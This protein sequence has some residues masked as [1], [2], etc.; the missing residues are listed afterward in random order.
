[1]NDAMDGL[2]PDA[3]LPWRDAHWESDLATARDA[4]RAL[5]AKL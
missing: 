4:G 3:H 2:Q 5:A 1:M